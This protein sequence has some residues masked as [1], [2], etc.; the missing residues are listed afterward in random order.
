MTLILP[1][2]IVN[3]T[4]ADAI[5]VDTNYKTIEQ[6]VNT[7]LVDR[8]G[9]VAMTGQLTLVGDP[10]SD[11]HAV[12]KAYV[13]ALLPVGIM[14]PWLGTQAPAGEWHLADGASLQVAQYKEL[15]DRI[16][17]AYGGEGGSFMLPNMRGVVPVGQYVGHERYDK[18]GNY[19][20]STLVPVPPHVHEMDH[21]HPSAA[22]GDD[23]TTHVHSIVHNHGSQQT[24]S[25]GDHQHGG[26]FTAATGT[27]GGFVARRIQDA[28]T[29]DT[30]TNVGGAHTHTVDIAQYTG[31]S[32]APKTKHKHNFDVPDFNGN[33]KEYKLEI[34]DA[35]NKK[36]ATHFYAPFVVINYIVRIA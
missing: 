8:N 24:G 11:N 5:P 27:G 30:L 7:N 10:L 23:T 1:N 12:R 18:V 31:D 34:T 35:D 22:T 16:G 2:E 32:G 6:Y 21:N 17:Y 26:E 20:G 9:S 28:G 14:L 19:G 4:P 15:H 13:D 25:A 36:S 33:T 29:T 3:D